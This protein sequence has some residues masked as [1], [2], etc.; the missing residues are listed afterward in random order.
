MKSIRFLP[1]M[2]HGLLDY[3]VGSL[4]ILVPNL[5]GFQDMGGPPVII[6]RMLGIGAILYSLITRYEWGVLKVLPMPAHLAIDFASGVLLAVSPWLFGFADR[7]PSVWMPHVIGG[8]L[9]IGVVL[10]SQTEPH[11]ADLTSQRH[12]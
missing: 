1:T 12:A 6:P 11:Q 8:L 5:F 10:V 3:V 4:L 7:P 9:E 2:V